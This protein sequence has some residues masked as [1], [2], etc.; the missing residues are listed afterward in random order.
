MITSAVLAF[1]TSRTKFVVVSAFPL[2]LR[3]SGL[4]RLSSPGCSVNGSRRPVM[5]RIPQDQTWRCRNCY[6][7]LCSFHCVLWAQIPARCTS[8][9]IRHRRLRT[10]LLQLRIWTRTGAGAGVPGG[11]RQ[12][13]SP[14]PNAF[15][16]TNARHIPTLRLFSAWAYE[17]KLASVHANQEDGSA[18][19]PA[20][21][22]SRWRPHMVPTQ[23]VQRA[24][25]T[26]GSPTS[27]ASLV[28]LW[29]AHG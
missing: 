24:R 2:R 23:W 4:G 7:Y 29:I 11:T 3:G 25:Y 12:P 22:L 14:G 28:W 9:V 10:A 18:H 5:T 15:R 16:G 6:L 20:L 27:P 8:T 1:D 13:S 17:A 26:V 19:G 21:A